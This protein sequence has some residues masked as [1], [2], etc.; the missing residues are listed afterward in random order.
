MLISQLCRWQQHSS[1]GPVVFPSAFN[2]MNFSS[3]LSSFTRKTGERASHKAACF[4]S[5]KRTQEA[6]LAVELQS[7]TSVQLK[8]GPILI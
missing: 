6:Y 8:S 7:Y 5:A 3:S 1:T 4:M 2:I